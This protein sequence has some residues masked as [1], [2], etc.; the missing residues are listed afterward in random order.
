MSSQRARDLA[1]SPGVQRDGLG[2]T[3]PAR[4]ER[5]TI[6]D[7]LLERD[8]RQ[9]HTGAPPSREALAA[10]IQRGENDSFEDLVDTAGR[11]AFGLAYR[12]L[13]DA[14]L[15]E[16][17]VQDAFLWLWEH[18]D[19]VD[20]R[21]GSA[22]ALLLTLVHRRAIDAYRVRVR[23]DRRTN[24]LTSDVA[25]EIDRRAATLVGEAGPA[26][27]P[28]HVREILNNLPREQR[29]IIELAFFEGC[30]QAEVAGRLGL[31]LG[32]VKSRVRLG[33]K[34]LRVALGLEDGS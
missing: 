5:P 31:P 22:E 26:L 3:S 32:T 21:R 12:V 23:R 13:G 7:P 29:E 1:A 34:K 14:R 2:S 24:P 16:D 30:T 6:P 4:F 20:P 19:R 10:R 28:A 11:R 15:A 18:Y 25:D 9:L 27:D 17:V 33:M 8:A